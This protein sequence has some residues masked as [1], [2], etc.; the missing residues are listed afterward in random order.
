MMLQYFNII[1]GN[2]LQYVRSYSFL[3]TIA[4]SLFIAFNFVPSPDANYTTVSFGGYTGDYTAEWIGFVTAILASTFLSLC[5]FF[6]V[7]GSIKKDIE[8]RIGHIIGTTK[9]SNLTYIFSKVTSNFLV[10]LTILFIIFIT[11]IALFFLY[12]NTYAFNISSFITPY[13]LIAIPT[14]FLIANLA[15]VLEVIFPTKRMLQYGVFLFLFFA[16]LFSAANDKT[17]I[18]S[19]DLFG[20]Q[21]VTSSVANEVQETFNKKDIGLSIGFVSGSR[22][23]EKT[24]Q[25]SS[26]SFPSWYVY[27]RLLWILIAVLA[28]TIASF[29]FHRFNYKESPRKTILVSEETKYKSADFKLGN[30]HHGIEM[31]YSLAPLI[32]AELLMIIRKNPSY[33][34][35]LTICGFTSM[36]FIPLNIAHLYILPILW[37]LQVTV[38]SDLV[39]KDQ[40]FRTHF[41]TNS[42]YHP[43]RRLAI[44]R[45]IAGLSV[46]ICIALPVLIRYAINLNFSS[47]LNVILGAIFIVLVAV[48]L[49]AFTKS[50]KT[51]EIAFFFLVYCN[52]NQVKALDYFGGLHHSYSYGFLMTAIVS[53]LFF[54]SYLL[55]YRNKTYGN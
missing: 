5:G 24:F 10:L 55:L 54:L 26:L 2:Y 43:L 11:G 32:Q 46:A 29:F 15:V 17:S 49:G 33:L 40:T 19:S 6:L 44:S 42:S 22:N 1:K 23:P 4:F 30:L 9:V 12:G 51:F 8:T 39:T 28:S 14:L 52:I 45:I 36:F 27:S 25:M 20:I 37:F 21:H 53:V 16:T 7:N 3:L 34:W 13:I 31:S 35:I 18:I 41:F 47:V 50:K 48:F 38:W